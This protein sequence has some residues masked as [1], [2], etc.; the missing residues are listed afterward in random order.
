MSFYK[1]I[2]K[3]KE[4]DMEKYIEEVTHED[5]KK[6]IEKEKLT[7]YDFL[8]LLSPKAKD[9]LEEMARVAQKRS[10]QQFGKIISLYIPIYISNYCTNECTYCGF[11]KNNKID[12]KHLNLN[13]IEIEAME[14]SKTGIRHILLLTGEAEGLVGIDYIENT[15]KILKKYFD[16]VVVEIYPLE[17]KEYERLGKIGVDGLTV[18]QE[19][20]DEKIYRSV[21]LGGKKSDY[22]WRLETPERGALAGLRSINIGPLFGLGDLVKEA[23]LSGLHAKY[24]TD[25]Y[26]NSE[27]S[28]S[29]PRINEAEGGYKSKYILDDSTFVQFLLAYRLFLPKAGINISTRE[30]AEF[31]DNLIG[32]GVTKFSAG[33]KTNVG[34]YSDM[35][36]STSQFEISDNRSVA[37]TEK[38][39]KARGYQVVHKDWELI[40]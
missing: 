3:F 37:E 20:Y 27:F 23:Y 10:V 8:N 32:L 5:I 15:V 24:L 18:Y 35:E 6:S 26:L 40:K 9:H 11:N 14:I 2:E 17:T 13:E 36:K 33:S 19:V 1:E 30:K 4:F 39:I 29:L 16:S 38:A 25:K 12:R 31:R 22:M 28:I 21:H 34:A 7:K